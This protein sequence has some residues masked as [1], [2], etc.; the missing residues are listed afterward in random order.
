MHLKINIAREEALDII[1]MEGMLLVL[2]SYIDNMPYVVAEAA[3]R[4]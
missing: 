3:V 1:G 2:C 4:P